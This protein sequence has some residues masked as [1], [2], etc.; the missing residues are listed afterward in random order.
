[1]SLGKAAA[2]FALKTAAEE[3]RLKDPKGGLTAAGRAHFKRTEGAN[4]KPGVKGPADTPEKL[5]RKGSFLSRM[6]GPGGEG[7]MKK[8]NGEPSRRALSARAWG[9]P[10][11]QNDSDRAALYAKGQR[12]L[13]R[14]KSKKEGAEAPRCGCGKT[15]LDTGSG[16]H[17]RT[18]GPSKDH[19][20]Y[21]K[22]S[23]ADE[24]PPW[25][26]DNPK[27]K[28]KPMTDSEKAD[29]KRRAR[30]AGRPYPNLVDNMAAKKAGYR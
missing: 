17:C 1:M 22:K 11:P 16:W 30:E 27:K 15:M 6:F 13:E 8:D 5:K 26:K 14:Y 23:A 20:G 21:A 10:V 28:S 9:E 29:A 3:K 25:E 2:L 24:K 4:L 12:L 18:C 19:D 7:S